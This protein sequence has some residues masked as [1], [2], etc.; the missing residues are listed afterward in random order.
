MADKRF[1]TGCTLLDLVVGGGL[2]L[3]FPLGK[4]IN[5]V[6]DKSSGK[7]FIACELVAKNFHSIKNFKYNFD[8]GE[9]GFTFNT[10]YLYGFDIVNDDSLRSKKIED[11]DINV[12]KFLKSLSKDE[13]GIYILDSLDGLSNLDIEKR[14]EEREK[15]HEKGKDFDKGTY[16][17]KTPK[18][19]SQE[20]FKT[21]AS[22]FDETNSMM[23]FISQTRDNIDPFSF[24]KWTRSGGKALDFYCHTVLWLATLK[25]IEKTVEGQKKTIGVRVKARTEKSKTPR[26]FRECVFTIYFDYGLDNVGSNLD[27]LFNLLTPT[28]ELSAGA[29]EIVWKGEPIN[30]SNLKEFL[31]SKGLTEK[32][33]AE[34][35]K[36]SGK[37]TLTIDFMTDYIKQDE[38][39]KKEFDKKFGVPI[40]RDKLIEQIEASPEMEKELE[41]RVIDKWEEI[42]SK[43]S[44]NR[45]KKYS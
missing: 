4:I 24:K 43:V 11:F 3:G 28:G 37:T 33:R 15:A 9:D 10:D 23:V 39:L 14:A 1:K 13:S 6:G 27:F 12:G 19:L 17:M 36:E 29:K 32:A 20:F 8:D 21:K 35:K 2:G 22:K 44:S 38:K 25:K 34:R 31:E 18:F 26:P 7:T 16:G 42:E 40:T 41:Q 5:I 30:L 45:K